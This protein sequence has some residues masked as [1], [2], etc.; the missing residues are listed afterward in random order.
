VAAEI[1]AGY[2]RISARFK[3]DATHLTG[4]ITWY[5]ALAADSSDIL[6]AVETLIYAV[7]DVAQDMSAD[8]YFDGFNFEFQAGSTTIGAFVGVPAIGGGMSGEWSSPASAIL[9][10]KAT[11]T[12]GRGS[13]GRFY[14]PGVVE[15]KVSTG[16]VL[17]AGFVLDAQNH[18]ASFLAKLASGDP[19][20]SSFE[21]PMYHAHQGG[22]VPVVALIVE[23]VIATQRRRLNRS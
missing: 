23:S 14:L 20:G 22:A 12:F 8:L 1:P 5:A 19:G 11:T 18:A 15:S 9:Y 6:G 3:N 10:Q 17:D 2:G 7:P 16:G 21:L 13:R 4:Y